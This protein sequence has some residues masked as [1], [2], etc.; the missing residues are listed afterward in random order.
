V[1]VI[2]QMRT[3]KPAEVEEEEKAVE[4]RKSSFE[5]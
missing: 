3:L 5:G 1:D 2:E 4:A